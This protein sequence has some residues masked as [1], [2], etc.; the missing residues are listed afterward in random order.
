MARAEPGWTPHKACGPVRHT[1]PQRSRLPD[2]LHPRATAARM[3]TRGE[4]AVVVEVFSA[5]VGDVDS[6]VTDVEAGAVARAIQCSRKPLSHA[7]THTV[8]AGPRTHTR[9]L[10]GKHGRPL[11]LVGQVGNKDGKVEKK[12]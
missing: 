4:H 10:D 12:R 5:H 11:G 6:L 8:G 7:R 3:P 9:S 2:R 1:T